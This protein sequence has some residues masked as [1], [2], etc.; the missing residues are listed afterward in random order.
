MQDFASTAL[1]NRCFFR[2]PTLEK[3][4]NADLIFARF[5]L[6]IKGTSSLYFAYA[7]QKSSLNRS[8]VVTSLHI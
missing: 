4:W 5:S 6:K 8:A 3:L 2:M 7:L 1:S